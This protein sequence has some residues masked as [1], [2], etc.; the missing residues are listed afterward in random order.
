[1]KNLDLPQEEPTKGDP[2]VCVCRCAYIAV[3]NQKP[4]QVATLNA[5]F[6]DQAVS[7]EKP[8]QAATLNMSLFKDQA[9]P[10]QK[11]GQVATLNASLSQL[12][13]LA[14]LPF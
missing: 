11:P 7:T 2:D 4:G 9:V 14:K 5:S 3:P 10:T 12:R 13:N 6:N 1:M 8:G